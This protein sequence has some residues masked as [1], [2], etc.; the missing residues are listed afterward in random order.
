[1]EW[2]G[3]PK[4]GGARLRGERGPRG[5]PSRAI[6]AAVP[7]PPAVCPPLVESSWEGGAGKGGFHKGGKLRGELA[8]LGPP[9]ALLIKGWRANAQGAC[10]AP[11]A[12]GPEL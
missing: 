3:N 7:V 9:T 11:T 4:G 5:F 6:T 1:M 12:V 10:K 2:P 8:L